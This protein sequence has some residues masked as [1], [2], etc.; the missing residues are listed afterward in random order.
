MIKLIKEKL[1][2][3][4]TKTKTKEEK[5]KK[6]TR[7]KKEKENSFNDVSKVVRISKMSDINNKYL[8]NIRAKAYKI[9]PNT[10]QVIVVVSH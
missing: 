6:K 2:P 10:I 4:S 8:K 7:K 3:K 5:I 9:I 1:I